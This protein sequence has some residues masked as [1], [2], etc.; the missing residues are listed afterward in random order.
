MLRLRLLDP[1]CHAHLRR[2]K[3]IMLAAFA[4]KAVGGLGLRCGAPLAFADTSSTL[5]SMA[6]RCYATG[7]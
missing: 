5:R 4:K 6:V 2:L 7:L 1:S 3:I